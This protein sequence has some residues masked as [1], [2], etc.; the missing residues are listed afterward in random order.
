MR[1]EILSDVSVLRSFTAPQMNLASQSVL[2]GL[3]ACL[4]H[5]GEV[6]VSVLGHVIS[7]LFA[8]WLPYRCISQNLVEHSRSNR[9]LISLP[10]RILHNKAEGGRAYHV[11]LSI[12]SLRLIH[13]RDPLL[14][15]H[16]ISA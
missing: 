6:G 2:E 10:A 12:D 14:I 13:G 1:C 9:A 16:M 15:T 3:N 7:L 11:P 5:R 4:D 8:V